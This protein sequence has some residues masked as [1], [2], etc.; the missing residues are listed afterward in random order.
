MEPPKGIQTERANWRFGSEVPDSFLDHVRRSVP[1]YDE[2]HELICR[3]SDFFCLPDSVCYEI[4]VSTGE[5]IKKLARYNQQK[6]DIRWIGI[7]IEPAM[8]TK[9]ESHCRDVPNIELS[10]QDIRL[11][12]LEKSDLIVSYYC[13]QF[14]P[15]RYRQEI[16]DK[17]YRALNWG[18]ALIL[19][20]KVRAPDARFQD[21]LTTL[22]NE[23]KLRNGFSAE[24]VLNKS[25]SLKGVLEPFSTQGNL[26]LLQR[27]G[28]VDVVTVMKNICFEGF[29]A[30]K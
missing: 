16:F 1:S 28:F 30:I 7:D 22:Y 17:I 2:G 15:A 5:L 27:A 10:C 18:G 9:A 20:E 8:I 11:V 3:L 21:I 13:I 29:L 25:L 14:I 12:E 4:G 24:E 6:P 23:F 26:G 19:F